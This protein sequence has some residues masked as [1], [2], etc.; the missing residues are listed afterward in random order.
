MK[1]KDNNTLAIVL[2]AVLALTLF[3]GVGGMMG[4]GFMGPGM[5]YGSYGYGFGWIFM[6]VYLAALVLLIIWLIKQIQK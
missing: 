5:M 4:Y 2:V 6:L 3:S 1:S